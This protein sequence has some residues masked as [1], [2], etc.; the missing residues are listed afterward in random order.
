MKPDVPSRR[1]TPLHQH[2]A[3]AA[4]I[5]AAALAALAAAC[6]GGRHEALAERVDAVM[7]P[8][9]ASHEFSGAVVLARKGRIIYQRGFGMAN[10]EAGV[11]FT[12]D[13]PADGGSLAKTLTAAGIWLLA[14][15]GRVDVDAPVNRYVR[16]Y[17]FAGTTVRQ[18]ISHSNGLPPYYEFFDPFFAPD[19]VR[20]TKKMLDVVARELPGPA[21]EPGTRFEYSNF[22]FD[23]AALLIERVTGRSIAQFL[24][25]RFFSRYGM[26]ATFARP[27]R[28][29]DWP[30]VRTM[31]YR[32]RDG[33]WQVVDVFDMEAFIG[34][35]NVYFSV[36][37]LSRWASANSRGPAIAPSAFAAGQQ[38]TL[39]DGR[40][41]P[42]TGLSWYC[43][44][45][46]N[47]CYNT[48]NINA[49]H[50]LAYWDR[51]RI[52]AVAFISNSAMSPWAT[53]TLQRN[54]VTVLAGETAE[55]G[56]PPE[57][58]AFDAAATAAL[59]GNWFAEELGEVT[60]SATGPGLRLRVD[61]GLEFDMFQVSREIFYVPGMDYWIGFTGV[62]A[63]SAMH[64]RSMFVDAVAT[65]QPRAQDA[66]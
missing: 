15:E 14:H 6:T 19:E 22:G 20:T 41:S 2:A 44:D 47:R 63:P 13:T 30:G 53:I 21:F 33:G 49:F 55:I 65:V 46:G 24:D 18:L 4:L 29:A 37:D 40:P 11:P 61:A 60:I 17:P 56:P 35:S 3:R 25:E 12:P 36:A 62:D 34:G 7:E 45:S 54:L 66:R 48:G 31:G 32:W 28:F 10:H 5:A 26:H 27:G 59:A 8:L 16:E 51:D 52:E 43:D 42:L 38:R 58:M 1:A 9:V 23:V 64:L 39:I 57:F 50:G